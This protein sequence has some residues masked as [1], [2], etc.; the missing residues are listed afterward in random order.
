MIKTAAKAIRNRLF[1]HQLKPIL[2]PIANPVTSEIEAYYDRE[3]DSYLSTYGKIIQASRPAS[4]EEFI[5]YLIDAIGL[6]D[7]MKVLDAGC[8]VCGPAIEFANRKKLDIHAITVSGVQVEESNK[9]I[10]E[11]NL[12]DC[13]HVKKGD[14]THLDAVYEADSFDKIFFLE[15]LGY[16]VDIR[17]VLSSA[18]KV[19]KRGGS[20][21]VKGFFEV[22]V[23]E[24]EK[25]KI[26]HHIIG[27]VRA[28]YLYKS[29]D[30]I[31][32]IAAFRE[33]GLYIEFVRP[34]AMKEDFTKAST[35][36]QQ[37]NL[38]NIYTTAINS[39]FQIVEVLE[40]KFKKIY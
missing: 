13:I 22:P 26:Q 34:F 28:E 2:Q 8:G 32:L 5:D 35:F 9:N 3:N 14:F 15:T 19:L 10:I 6:E 39:S 33:L 20:I 29:V 38:H 37:N 40:V 4:D 12:I 31:D 1:N 25:R 7:G 17:T 21:Y 30:T 16:A 18:V 23:L 24:A 36:E 27:Q 11:A